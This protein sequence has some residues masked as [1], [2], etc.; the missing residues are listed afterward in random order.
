MN[1]KKKCESNNMPKQYYETESST[2]S[3]DSN[4]YFVV[5]V[6]NI[7]KNRLKILKSK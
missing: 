4:A 1:M 7:I 5:G 6:S 2:K 3:L